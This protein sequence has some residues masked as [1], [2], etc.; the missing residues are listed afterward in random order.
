MMNYKI[1]FLFLGVC[2]TNLSSCMVYEEYNSASYRTYTYD[3]AQLY[4]QADYRMYNYGYQNGP[5][6]SGVSVPDS[7]HVGEYHSPVSFKDRDRNWVNGQNPQGYTIQ[8]ADD[9]KASKVAQ[10][11]YKAP[12]NDRMAQIKYQRNGKSYYKGLYGT[13]D[14]QEAAQKALDELPPEIKQGAGVTNWG[15][16]QNNMDE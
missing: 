7:Y 11:L 13:Y 9:E 8:V 14:S 4:P 1:R 15:N 16:V 12:K 6:Q 10:K 2:I 5:A 3:D